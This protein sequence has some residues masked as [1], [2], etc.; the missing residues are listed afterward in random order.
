MTRDYIEFI[1]Y[2]LCCELD[3]VCSGVLFM[4]D[5]DNTCICFYQ[6]DTIGTVYV[7]FMYKGYRVNLNKPNF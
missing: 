7:P 5:S 4:Y 3:E 2:K 1:L 6:Y